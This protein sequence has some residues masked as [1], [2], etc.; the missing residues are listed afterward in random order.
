MPRHLG[1]L[2]REFPAA[3]RNG[4]I[5][6]VC[7]LLL[8]GVLYSLYVDFGLRAREVAQIQA[9]KYSLGWAEFFAQGIAGKTAMFDGEPPSP[10]E[11]EFLSSALKVPG[12]FRFKLFDA[13]GRLLMVSDA[14]GLKLHPGV[15]HNV[16]VAKE[17]AVTGVAQSFLKDG[18][19]KPD[20]PDVYVE[21]YVPVRV[22]GKI[23]GVA[24]VYLDETVAANQIHG[25]F[26]ALGTLVAGSIFILLL[27]PGATVLFILRRLRAQRRDLI[28]QRTRAE[29]AEQVKAN[30][31][32]CM[33]HDL[34][35][36]LNSIL[37]FSD[38]MRKG[39]GQSRKPEVSA[40][41][42]EL[43]HRSGTN[44]LSLVNDILELSAVESSKSTYQANAVDL[45]NVLTDC[46]A[47]IRSAYADRN[48]N[49]QLD[50]PNPVPVPLVHPHA[51]NRIAVN[52]LSNAVK[53]TPDGG[54]IEIR[55]GTDCD[56]VWV[57]FSDTGIGIS[58][59]EIQAIV[60]PFTQV[61]R[62]PHVARHGVGLGL[63]IVRGLLVKS[64][65]SL[66]I[67][68]KPGQGTTVTVSLP[69]A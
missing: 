37:G 24:E 34:R 69:S 59:E 12:I 14:S 13:R 1:D 50:L 42:A 23:L 31:M 39:I 27:L 3:V 56:L 16:A 32:A 44:M 41:Y 10:S 21:S 49:I 4:V 11:R 60:E 26:L 2:I 19:A 43:I 18:R 40:E 36:P 7:V 54:Q 55:A 62:D 35:T 6:I 61:D 63:A 17:V 47:E 38:L 28:R 57:A 25:E 5:S 22:G 9:E 45:Q 8:V 53:F 48:V 33:S 58:P 30:F 68:S 52:I 66:A 51:M 20:R 64:R 46:V 15:D 67:D 65:G 29:R